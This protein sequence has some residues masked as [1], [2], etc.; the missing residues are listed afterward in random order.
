V[1]SKYPIFTL[2]EKGGKLF[3]KQ[4]GKTIVPEKLL[5]M[6]LW[7]L[8]KKCRAHLEAR[9][10]HLFEIMQSYTSFFKSCKGMCYFFGR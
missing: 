2:A 6:G 5:F 8:A 7:K 9:I 4:K 1:V 3:C 10:M